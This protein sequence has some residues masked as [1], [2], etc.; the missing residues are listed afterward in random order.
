MNHY[1]NEVLKNGEFG[2]V[3]E[4]RELTNE[5]R[6]ELNC[7]VL[8]HSRGKNRQNC[9]LTLLYDVDPDLAHMF[10]ASRYVRVGGTIYQKEKC[11]VGFISQLVYETLRD[12]EKFLMKPTGYDPLFVKNKKPA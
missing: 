3:M 12:Y 7:L 5:V 8:E 1:N 6:K 10:S 9:I 11:S 2:K 4:I